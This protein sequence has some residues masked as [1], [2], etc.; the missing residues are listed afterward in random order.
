MVYADRMSDSTVDDVDRS[1]SLWAAAA[2][3]DDRHDLALAMLDGVPAPHDDEETTVSRAALLLRAGRAPEA[4]AALA[5]CGVS[6]LPTDRRISWPLLVLAGSLAAT[7]DAT[8]YRWLLASAGRMVGAAEAWRVSYL[9][10]AAAAG[11]GERATADQAWHDIVSRHHIITRVSL[12][13]FSAAQV[14]S[15]DP[16][17]PYEVTTTVAAAVANLH[18]CGVPVHEDP[19]PVLDAA[20]A[21]TARGDRP[22]ARLLLH[23]ARR[24]IP[25]TPELDSALE[26]LTPTADMRRH[27]LLVTTFWC[28][29]PALAPLGMFGMLVVLAVRTVWE[30]RVCIPGLNLADSGA[31]RAFRG[32]RYDPQDDPTGP[33]PKDQAGYYGL[34]ALLSLLIAIPLGGP[35][36]TAVAAL[37]G[38]ASPQQAS[39]KLMISTWL[40]LCLG[41]PFLAFLGARYVHRRLRA[42]RIDRQRAAAQRSRHTTAQRCQCWQ[43]CS[44]SGP[45]AAE[46]LDRHLTGEPTDRLTAIGENPTLGRCPSTGALWIAIRQPPRSNTLLLRGVVG[47]HEAP[48]GPSGFYL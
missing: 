38:A 14:A 23:A 21:L 18:H 44:M 41:I 19:A 20:R 10:A 47:D 32:V 27:R 33:A 43:I 9:V 25:A 46:Y 3:D 24:R 13:Q 17:D 12:A 16:A 42:H 30:R 15:R 36:T 5:R 2:D 1:W 6:E 37:T 48:T 11:I 31:W 28:L 34:V 22:G 26:S 29:A 4:V 45:L 40:L 35:A 7:G 8:A 39:Q